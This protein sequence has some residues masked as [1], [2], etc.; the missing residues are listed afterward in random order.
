M[1]RESGTMSGQTMSVQ[2]RC[3]VF[4]LG[5]EES[6]GLLESFFCVH[7]RP[8]DDLLIPIEAEN[9]LSTISAF[10]MMTSST[11]TS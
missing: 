5:E 11:G 8:F 10:S 7:A 2:A 6:L 4:R 1:N 9:Q 3:R